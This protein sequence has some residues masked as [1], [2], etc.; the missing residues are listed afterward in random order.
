ML[1]Q[2]GSSTEKLLSMVSIREGFKNI[3]SVTKWTFPL[4]GGWGPASPLSLLRPFFPFN[5]SNFCASWYSNFVNFCQF[6]PLR[7]RWV[8]GVKP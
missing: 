8:G 4:S 5:F 7:P 2:T 6:C 3:S 1:S